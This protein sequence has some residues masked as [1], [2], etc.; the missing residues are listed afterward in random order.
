MRGG[1]I[2]VGGA[3]GA[4]TALL[5]V[6]VPLVSMQVFASDSAMLTGK[7][8]AARLA[9]PVVDGYVATTNKQLCILQVR[10]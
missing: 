2:C 7:V 3:Y 6:H 9:G 5:H 1:V 8:A 4:R 10:E